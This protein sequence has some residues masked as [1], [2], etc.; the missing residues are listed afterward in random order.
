M[1]V[2]QFPI[3]HYYLASILL[4][5]KLAE[6]PLA[7]LLDT[8]GE[9]TVTGRCEC[10]ENTCNTMYMQSDSLVGKDGTYCFGFNIGFIIFS[11]YKDGFF[12]LESLADNLSEF[13]YPFYQEIREI[14]AG[15][16]VFYDDAY[17]KVAVEYFMEGLKRV[18]VE[19]IDV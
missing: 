5:V 4:E 6:E 12:M 1:K 14:L 16:T 11:F 3:Y 19:R 10:G 2:K 7:H 17:A 8:V 9:Y 13:N 18:D 15:R